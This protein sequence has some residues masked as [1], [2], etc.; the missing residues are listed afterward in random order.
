MNDENVK[1]DQGATEPGSAGCCGPMMAEMAKECPCASLMK[2][3]RF[4][5]F[6]VISLVF[7]MF[8]ISQVGGILGI[9]AFFR[10]L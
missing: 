10:T 8:L 4:A 6:A 5:A 9:I 3:H 1:A 7:L 2:K